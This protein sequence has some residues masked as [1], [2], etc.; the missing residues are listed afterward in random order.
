MNKQRFF[1]KAGTLL[2]AVLLVFLLTGCVDQTQGGTKE[3][4]ETEETEET[5]A[6]TAAETDG[7]RIV[8]TSMAVTEVCEKLDLDLV[9]IPQSSLSDPPTRYADVTTVGSPM[10][11]DLEIID[12][13]KADWILSPSSL[14]SDL[15]PKYE[16]L[17]IHYA[18]LNLKSVEG[19]YKSM[20]E[21]GEI[22]ARKKRRQSRPR[23]LKSFMMHIPARMRRMKSRKCLY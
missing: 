3:T 14:Q 5:A 1:T 12:S 16:A 10:A 6:D 22:S 17:G 8:A 18:F 15:Q 2:L 9:G 23:S 11:P 20:E 7:L 4:E 19:M 13:L 21:L